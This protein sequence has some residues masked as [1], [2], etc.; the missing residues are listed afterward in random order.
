MNASAEIAGAAR[1][2][3]LGRLVV[4]P[5]DTLLGL[6]ARADRAD[7][8]R[9]LFRAKGRPVSGTVSFAVS[10]YEEIERFAELG[11]TARAWIRDRLPGPFTVLVRARAP[12]RPR[13]AP[14]VVGPGG[15]LG[16]RIPDHPVARELARRVGPIVAT[17]ANR[18][19]EPPAR[20]VE[21]A[22][23]ALG[24]RVARYVRLGP[25]PSGRPSEIV[26]L[27]GATPRRVSR[28]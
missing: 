13:L 28:R 3:S 20:T 22:R 23:Q 27:T 19:G 8:V 14:G 21:A 2:L 10:S 17:S 24:R 11:T 18:H 16:V 26:D 25:R 12:A 15:I 1:A 7:A 6:G 4:Y 9:R 5:T